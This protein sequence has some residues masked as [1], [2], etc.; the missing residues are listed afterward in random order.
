M[1]APSSGLP[2]CLSEIVTRYAMTEEEYIEV[3]HTETRHVEVDDEEV[4]HERVAVPV[5][6]VRSCHNACLLPRG[7]CARVRHCTRK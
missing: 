2:C 3:P 4:Y 1:E 5:G 7:V 6:T